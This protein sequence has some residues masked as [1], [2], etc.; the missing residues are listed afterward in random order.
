MSSILAVTSLAYKT[1]AA[2]VP[3][4]EVGPGIEIQQTQPEEGTHQEE[5]KPDYIVQ[6]G[7]RELDL[8]KPMIALTFDDGPNSKAGNE[9]MDSLESYNGRA[10]FFVVGERV[11]SRQTVV[12]RM[13]DNGH[14]IGNHSMGHKYF[15]KLDAEGIRNQVEACNNIVEEVTG[16]RPVLMRLPGGIKNDTVMQNI[17][18]PV[19]SWNIDTRDWSTK[20]PAKTVE[21]VIGKVK[22]GDIVLMHELY[23]ETAE[24]VRQMLPQLSEQGFQFVTVSELIKFKGKTVEPNKIYYSFNP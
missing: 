22:D 23:S 11:S 16:V 12:K 24:A 3:S 8:R 1:D 20:D 19:I 10:T 21:A 9:I 18:M 2:Y 15:H 5:K 14:E 13:I 4:E 7:G 6:S 17:G